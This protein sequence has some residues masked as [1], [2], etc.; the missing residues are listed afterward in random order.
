MT[1]ICYDG[2]YLAVDESMVY[3]YIKT[4]IKKCIV[5]PD[6]EVFDGIDPGKA[7]VAI[8]GYVGYKPVIEEFLLGKR[9]PPPMQ[10]YGA[11]HNSEAVGLLVIHRRCYCLMAGMGLVEVLS[12][13][14]TMGSATEFLQGFCASYLYHEPGTTHDVSYLHGVAGRAVRAAEVYCESVS[15]CKVYDTWAD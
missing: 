7:W 6:C 5:I 13:F 8:T 15:G 9:P 2:R 11:S 4:Q 3:G 14:V 10:E 12:P 1:A